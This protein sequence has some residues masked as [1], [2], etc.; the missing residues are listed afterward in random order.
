MTLTFNSTFSQVTVT[1][2][3]LDAFIADSSNVLV[4]QTTKDCGTLLSH[5]ISIGDVDSGNSQY[6]V[7]ASTLGYGAVFP[8]GVYQFR[9]R[10]QDNPVTINTRFAYLNASIACKLIDWYAKFLECLGDKPCNQNYFYWVF[11]FDNLLQ[12]FAAG[13]CNDFTYSNA[14]K[15]Y[16][17]MLELLN[18]TTTINDDCGCD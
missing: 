4:L 1:G 8:E 2:T 15:L 9:L 14:C 6:V 16:T 3:A 5:T 18:D 17:K 7:T 10:Y 13:S 12:R 11:V